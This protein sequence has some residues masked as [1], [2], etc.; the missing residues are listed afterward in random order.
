[1]IAERNKDATNTNQRSEIGKNLFEAFRAFNG[2]RI[3]IFV[4]S[5][6]CKVS[7]LLLFLLTSVSDIGEE[8]ICKYIIP[9]LKLLASDAEFLDS[10]HRAM[11][12][13]M[14]RDMETAVAMVENEA[15]KDQNK[16]NPWRGLF[17]LNKP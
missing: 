7:F 11:I 15:N 5:F 8:T 9:G 3:L 2:C 12:H 16:A 4:N 13:S 1:V 17:N 10:S 14:I 6:C